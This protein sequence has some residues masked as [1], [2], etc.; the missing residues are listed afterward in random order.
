MTRTGN[1]INFWLEF[2][3]ELRKDAV[4]IW[5]GQRQIVIR[6]RSLFER[7]MQL[8]GTGEILPEIKFQIKAAML[9]CHLSAKTTKMVVKSNNF[10]FN[11]GCQN[12]ARK[13]PFKIATLYWFNI[14]FGLFGM[15]I[16]NEVDFGKWV[17]SLRK[18]GSTLVKDL[19]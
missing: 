16:F 13:N 8:S 1:L 11:N 18:S 17:S 12:C 15:H 5:R 10:N 19:G 6:K 2:W 14:G 9:N 4:L 3:A 7:G